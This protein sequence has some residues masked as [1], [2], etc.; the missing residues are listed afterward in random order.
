MK[1]K[2]FMEGNILKLLEIVLI[3]S[4]ILVNAAVSRLFDKYLLFRFGYVKTT[5]F[6]LF[7]MLGY[8][9]IVVIVLVKLNL[10]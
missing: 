10:K 4:V 1:F 8:V 6:K 5:L 7:A 2:G 3:L 9:L